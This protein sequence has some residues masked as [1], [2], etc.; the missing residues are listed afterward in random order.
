MKYL[1]L[2]PDGAADVTVPGE[3]TPLEAA[4]TPTMDLLARRGRV[5]LVRTIPRG[6]APGS[7]AANMAVLGYDPAKDLTGRSPLEAVSMGIELGPRDVAFRANLVTLSD[8]SGR[9]DAAPTGDFRRG[10]ILP[11]ETG[12]E[13][14]GPEGYAGLTIVDHASGDIPTEEARALIEYVDA[15]IGSGDPANG[16]RVKFY[17][18]VSY[19]HAFVVR[20]EGPKPTESGIGDVF[21]DYR[22]YALVPPHD[23]LGRQIE[24]YLPDAQPDKENERYLLTLMEKSY[25]LLKDHE[26]NRARVA[27]GL[28]PANSLWIWGEGRRPQ[29]DK[30]AEKYGVTGSVIS[31]VDLIKGIGICAG[32]SPVCV[33]GATG[34]ITTNFKGKGQAAIDAFKSGKDLAYIHV[35]APDECAHQGN[36]AEKIEALTRIDEDIVAPVLAYLEGCGEDFRILIVPDHRTPVVIRTH[37]DEPVPF[38]LY[39]SRKAAEAAAAAGGADAAENPAHAFTER[40]GEKGERLHSGRELADAFFLG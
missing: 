13:V 19:R 21:E 14:G 34:T 5:G 32:L 39:D 24:L 30:V 38:V 17:P 6:V 35:E 26:I 29:L 28:R 37:T 2:V 33:E 18:G 27:K 10:G 7:D 31:A 4:A 23:I 22:G 40:A 8:E 25:A 1:I 15:R 20:D 36:R 3:A 9:Q 16:G 11:P 12:S